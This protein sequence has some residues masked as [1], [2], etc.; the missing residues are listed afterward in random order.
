MTLSGIEAIIFDCDGVLVDSEVIHIAVERE[1]LAEDGLRYSDEEYLTRF[2]GLSNPDFHRELRGDYLSR[3]DRE[4]PYDFEERLQSRLWPRVERELKAITGVSE[5]VDA[6]SGSVAVASSSPPDRLSK[7]L[8]MTGL[9]DLFAPHIYSA[10]QVDRG[11]PS[12][13]LFLFAAAALGVSPGRCAVIEDSL[14]GITA[15]K[16]AGMRAIGFVGGAHADVGLRARLL[17]GGAQFVV[18]GHDE[19]QKLA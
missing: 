15:A 13:D 8:T 9:A 4:F 6:F 11:K 3:A 16:R 10:E 12:P 14:H 7:K 2:V 17:H 5:L 19:V 18:S 1:L